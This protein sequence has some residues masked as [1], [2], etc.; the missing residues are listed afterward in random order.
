MKRLFCLLACICMLFGEIVAQYIPTA[1]DYIEVDQEPEPFNL[2]ETKQ[3]IGYPKVARMNC[4]QGTVVVRILLD[5]QGTYI[6]HIVLNDPNPSLTQAVVAHIDQLSFSPAEKE[7]NP[8]K[9]W[10]NIPFSFKLMGDCQVSQESDKNPPIISDN[11]ELDTP[12]VPLNMREIRQ[13]IGYPAQAI[14]KELEGKVVARILV[15]EKGEYIRHELVRSAHPILADAVSQHLPALSFSPA[16]KEGKALKF[17]VNI[18]FQ[19]KLIPSTSTPESVVSELAISQLGTLMLY[20]NPA[21]QS[22][23]IQLRASQKLQKIQLLLID[24]QGKTLQKK[25]YQPEVYQWDHQ[26]NVS[27]LPKGVYH[28]QVITE[29][30]VLKK[31]WIKN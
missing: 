29:N 2:L 26:L 3:R 25:I 10:V 23:H 6:Q 27:Q 9:Y 21:G 31:S 12:P 19:F 16:M 17:W 5:E 14:D 18:P 4:V 1:S 15:S 20:P 11:I 13:T 28:I 30:D 22:L 24:Q 7:G 8:I